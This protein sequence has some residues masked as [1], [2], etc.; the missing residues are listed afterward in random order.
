MKQNTE[1]QWQAVT[2]TI[3][4]TMV[5]ILMG[6]L[7]LFVFTAKEL[8]NTVREDL[9]MTLIVKDSVNNQDAL[10]M[11]DRIKEKRFVRSIDY[12]SREEALQ[13]QIETLNLDPREFLGSNPF[14]ISMELHLVA[15]YACSD[16]IQT[17]IDELRQESGISDIIYQKEMMDTLN[18]NLQRIT[19]ALLI[20]TGLLSFISLSLINSTVRLS[21]YSRRFIIH[22]MKLVG[23]SWN[24]IRRPF[25]VRSL[26]LG[27]ISSVIANTILVG[28]TEWLIAYEPSFAPYITHQNIAIMVACVTVFGIIITTLCTFVS[29][30]H[31]LRMRENKLYK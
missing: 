28:G 20:I 5:L 4:T 17:V 8:R 16:S 9:T 6:I 27:V 24:F 21:V 26:C 18:T 10:N 7:L 1:L 2:S 30:T 19:I 3:S 23:A 22:T 15:E 29:V 31:F 12:V 25:L 11:R 14:S 13:E